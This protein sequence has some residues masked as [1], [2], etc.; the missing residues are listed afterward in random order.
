MV[1]IRRAYEVS[2]AK[3][4]LGF[5][6]QDEHEQDHANRPRPVRPSLFGDRNDTPAV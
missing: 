1:K 5:D 2:F 4:S 6:R 3:F